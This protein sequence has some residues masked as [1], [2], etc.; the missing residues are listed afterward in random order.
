MR[1]VV[2]RRRRRDTKP[3]Q[4]LSLPR[5]ADSLPL[6]L[7]A[8]A[9]SY[10][11]DFETKSSLGSQSVSTWPR[12]QLVP[13]PRGTSVGWTFARVRRPARARMPRGNASCVILSQPPVNLAC[14]CLS[15][16]LFCRVGLLYLEEIKI[17]EI[18][19]KCYC[20][21]FHRKARFARAFLDFNFLLANFKIMRSWS[22]FQNFHERPAAIIFSLERACWGW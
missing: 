7:A 10:T 15:L 4:Q 13:G 17:F 14:W 16:A 21:L 8:D 19:F 11:F 20:L 22:Y 2:L 18:R 9:W 6:P 12:D 5:L 3:L 1:L